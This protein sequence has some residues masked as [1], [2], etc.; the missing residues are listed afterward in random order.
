MIRVIAVAACGFG[1]SACN[2]SWMPSMPDMPSFPSMPKMSKV[3]LGLGS[4]FGP[5]PV[6]LRV[7]SVPPGAEATVSP[8][9][10][11][12]TPCT[13]TFKTAGDFV[14]NVSL[15][16]YEPQSLPVSV[17]PPEDPRFASEGAAR[18]PRL[19]P[20]SLFVELKAVPA[21]ERSSP[22]RAR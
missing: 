17:L 19:E 5:Q 3:D 6:A 21:R 10:N 12:R 18:G 22:R 9:T 1:L 11:C 8:T 2:A 20:D 14:V 7:E 13:L 15:N 16:G 4:L